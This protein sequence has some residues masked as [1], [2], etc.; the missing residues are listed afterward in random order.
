MPLR[1]GWYVSLHHQPGIS[2]SR[3]SLAFSWVNGRARQRLWHSRLSGRVQRH[4][5]ETQ[6][7]RATANRIERADNDAVTTKEVTRR[8]S[9]SPAGHHREV[10]QAAQRPR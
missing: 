6:P 1:W 8:I 3:K 2:L 9:A 5:F 10:P 7:S 4:R